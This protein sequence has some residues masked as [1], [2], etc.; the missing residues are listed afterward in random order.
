[1]FK[2][3]MWLTGLMLL[4]SCDLDTE[5]TVKAQLASRLYLLDTMH[6]SSKGTC[7]AAVFTLAL[8]EFRKPYFTA[9]TLETAME[10]VRGQKDVLF[11][12]KGLTP[13]EVTEAIMS[14]D[15]SNG[16]G[17]ISSGIGPARDCMDA[18]ISRGYYRVLMSEQT[19]MVYLPEENAL[20]LLY[21]PEKLAFFLRG[22]V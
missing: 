14:R 12:L 22:N 10:R 13:H 15:L 3:L 11:A 18:R 20:L 21:P 7:T 19:Q 16:L 8:G 6:F 2:L 5:E 9:D 4:A 1:M 17:L